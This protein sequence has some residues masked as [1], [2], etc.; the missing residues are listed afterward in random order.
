M[1]H[2]FVPAA[3]GEGSAGDVVVVRRVL[4]VVGADAIGPRWCLTV[5]IAAFGPARPEEQAEMRSSG[6]TST[7]TPGRSRADCCS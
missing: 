4:S 2:A 6:V 7:G 3:I 5:Y 1:R